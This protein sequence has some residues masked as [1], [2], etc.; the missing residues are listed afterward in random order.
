MPLRSLARR[1][2]IDKSL[3]GQLGEPNFYR[4]DCRGLP[5]PFAKPHVLSHIISDVELLAIF[6]E[7]VCLVDEVQDGSTYLL[8][9]GNTDD[10]SWMKHGLAS[11]GAGL[12]L[13]MAVNRI[14]GKRG[15]KVWVC[16]LE[17]ISAK[18]DI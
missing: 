1:R 9:S 3:W 2:Q 4:D 18:L 6:F 10:S 13:Q 5:C 8:V 14:L 15:V 17:L 12:Q 11:Y 7:V 16:A